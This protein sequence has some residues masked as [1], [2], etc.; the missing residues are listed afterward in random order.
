MPRKTKTKTKTKTTRAPSARGITREWEFIPRLVVFDLDFTLWYPEMYELYGAPFKKDAST[1]AVTDRSGEEVHFFPAVHSVLSILETDPQFKDTTEVAVASKTTE[2]HWAKTCMRL[3][4]VHVSED[5][6]ADPNKTS[7]QSVVDYEAIYPRN[8]RVHFQQLKEQS[9]I[10]YE[11]MLFF[12]NEYG[13]IVDVGRIGVVCAYCPQGLSEGS[14]IQGME[15]FQEA[16]R[17]QKQN[18]GAARTQTDGDY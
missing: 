6:D 14:W 18:G 8:K 3:M 17:K 12:D 9:G 11:D 13:N 4:D 15:T 2:P 16:K 10:E 7:L 5:E 1:G